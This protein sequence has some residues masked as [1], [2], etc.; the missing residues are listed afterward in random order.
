MSTTPTTASLHREMV[1]ALRAGLK[2]KHCYVCGFN[3][4]Y[5]GFCIQGC[6]GEAQRKAARA[7]LE[8]WEK[9]VPL[10]D[11]FDLLAAIGYAMGWPRSEALVNAPTILDALEP[12]LYGERG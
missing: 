11:D 1:E 4:L 10:R 5:D 2:A 9:R 12:L 6:P 3:L 8:G 7:A